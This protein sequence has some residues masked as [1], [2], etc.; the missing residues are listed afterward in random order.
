[1]FNA[2]G[3][4]DI[5]EVATNLRMFSNVVDAHTQLSSKLKF[6]VFP[7]GTRVSEMVELLITDIC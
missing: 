5:K 1:M 6:V 4:D 2:V 3:G 7:G